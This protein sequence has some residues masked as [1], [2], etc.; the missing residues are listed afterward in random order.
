MATATYYA[1]IR[2]DGKGVGELGR[3]V[4]SLKR[5]SESLERYIRRP[6]WRKLLGLEV[7]GGNQNAAI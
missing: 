3:L 1:K 7:I 4:E 5:S 2:I 6:W